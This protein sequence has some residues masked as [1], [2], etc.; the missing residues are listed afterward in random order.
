MENNETTLKANSIGKF[1]VII[2]AISAAAPVMCLTG[3]LGDIMQGSGTAA[4]LA[5]ILATLVLIMVGSS[6]GQLSAKYNSAG[7]TYA[8]VRGVFGE[9]AGFVA[10]WLNMGVTI[11]TGVIGAVFSTYLH[12]LVPAIPMWAGILILLIPI[13]FIGWRGVELSTKTLIVVW[14]IQMILIIYP[15]IRIWSIQANEVENI[16]QN[17]L[18]A[19]KPTY[20]VSGLMLGVLVCVWCYVGFEC[21]AYMGEELKGGNK[22]V[23]FAIPVSAIGIGLIY[24]ISCWLWTAGMS[25]ESF[26][27]I[28]GSGTLMVDYCKLVGYTM[29]GKLV[30]IGALV[31]CIGC[32][33]AFSTSSPRGLFDMGRNGYL[34]AATSKVNKYQTPHI[35]LII[36]CILWLAAALYGA[37]GN[38]GHLFTF[39]ALFASATYI[40][41]CAANIKDRWSEKGISAFLKNKLIPVIAIAILAYM[42]L[43]SD[44]TSLMVSGIWLVLCIVVAFIWNGARKKQRSA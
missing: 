40:M 37:Y 3:S 39:M 24:A 34:P 27:A 26:D 38:M 21:P 23:K 33:I 18:Q 4:A 36:Y 19:F 15:A 42:I 44:N 28:S 5:F 1:D 2:M 6:Y 8:Y 16:L 14:V 9:R 20:G 35:S 31:S 41:V 17:S 10:A 30:S 43:S 22:A 7:G 25:K 13:F 29:G 32:F 11:C 12:E